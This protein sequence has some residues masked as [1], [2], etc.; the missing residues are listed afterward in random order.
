MIKK[1]LSDGYHQFCKYID[2]NNEVA[3]KLIV[4]RKSNGYVI[5]AGW[6]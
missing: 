4:V 5:L 6:K 3:D 1:E 2:K